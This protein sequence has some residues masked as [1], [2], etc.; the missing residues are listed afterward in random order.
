MRYLEPM[1]IAVSTYSVLPAPVFPWNQDNMRYSIC[2]FPVVGVVIGALMGGWYALAT[3]LQMSA[4]LFSA[5][6]VALPILI[7]GGIH[8]DGFLDTVDALSS[9][10]SRERK[11]EILKDSHCGA[12]AVIYC[13]V[14]VLAGFGFFYE[15]YGRGEVYSL[16]LG[17][18]ISRCLS[19]LCA[20]TMKNARGSGMLASFTQSADRKKAAWILGAGAAV[21]AGLEVFLFGAA[22]ACV[23]AAAALTVVWYRRLAN[24]EFGGATGDTSGFFLQMC[25]LTI[26]VGAWIGSML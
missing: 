18:V 5:A 17:F 23:I 20:V 2:F 11:L 19:G 24:K 8:M 12:F 16:C 7:S 1:W 21:F 6:A 13:C 25:E 9:H 14:Y 26:L 22:G 10:Q 3:C 15:V 4:V